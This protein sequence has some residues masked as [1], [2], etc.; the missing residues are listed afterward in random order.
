MIEYSYI[1]RTM[2]EVLDDIRKLDK[3]KNYG[4]LMSLVEELQMMG[5][6]MEAHLYNKKDVHKFIRLRSKLKAQITKLKEEKQELKGEED[7]E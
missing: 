7:E 3:T 4:P 5:N 6:R 1:N 2:C